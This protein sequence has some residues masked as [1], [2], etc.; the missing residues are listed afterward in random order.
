MKKYFKTSIYLM[1]FVLLVQL[2][3]AH[4]LAKDEGFEAGDAANTEV[5]VFAVQEGEEVELFEDYHLEKMVISIPDGTS[6]ELL[7]LHENYSK[8][9]YFS[10][11]TE[12]MWIGFVSNS[13]VVHLED[14]E[15]FLQQRADVHKPEVVVNEEPEVVPEEIE[16]EVE[17]EITPNE[18]ASEND[19]PVLKAQELEEESSEV[20]VL[21]SSEIIKGVALKA[22]TKVYASMSTTSVAL[23]SYKQGHILQFRPY[24]TDWY[25]A[26]VYISGEARTG[27]LHKNDV[28]VL[29]DQQRVE[30]YAAVQSVHVYQNATRNSGVLKSY[31]H[32][33]KLIYRTF[34]SQWH[35]ATV[36]VNGKRQTGYIHTDD[37]SI[38]L[39]A[40]VTVKGLAVAVGFCL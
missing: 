17:E 16:E 29:I 38:E 37:V 26:T 28:D 2:F 19:V 33:A 35:Q 15:E 3:P 40:Q 25:T 32:G 6:V 34:S 31:K 24:N 10:T 11:S 8:I 1:I 12:S 21:A 4:T 30:G 23:K 22:P 9:Q 39:P 36:I 27:Y 5:V 13:H 14:I 18:L 20:N 7:E